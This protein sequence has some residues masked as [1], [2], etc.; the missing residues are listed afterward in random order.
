[1]ILAMTRPDQ[2]QSDPHKYV[3]TLFDGTNCTAYEVRPN[4]CRKFPY[5]KPCQQGP[6]CTST[7]ARAGRVGYRVHLPLV[8]P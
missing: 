4:M 5:D 6:E 7:A 8:R 2:S 3:C 1:M